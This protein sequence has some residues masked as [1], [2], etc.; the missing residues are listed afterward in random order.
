[1]S[2]ALAP[3]SRVYQMGGKWWVR[4]FGSKGS[5]PSPFTTKREAIARATA[6]EIMVKERGV[7]DADELAVLKSLAPPERGVPKVKLSSVLRAAGGEPPGG[8]GAADRVHES[9]THVRAR[10]ELKETFSV[11]PRALNESAGAIVPLP[12][13][14]NGIQ[15]YRVRCKMQHCN[16]VNRNRRRYWA[17]KTWG[18]HTR[19]DAP[20]LMRV[21]ARRVFGHLEHPDSGRSNTKLAAIVITNVEKP[22]ETGEVFGTFETMS[23]PDGIIVARFIEDGVGFGLSSRGEGSVVTAPDG[24]DDVTEDFDPRS[25][26]VVADES[27]PGAEVGAELMALRE[28]ARRSRTLLVES[29]GGRSELAAELARCES[30]RVCAVDLGETAELPP[31]GHNQFL[32]GTPDQA[33][34]YRAYQ[35]GLAQWSVWFQA[36]NLPPFEVARAMPTLKDAKAAAEAHLRWHAGTGAEPGD[37]GGS[38]PPVPLATPQ[39]P[40][41]YAA[42]GGSTIQAPA[43]RPVEIKVSVGE[44]TTMKKATRVESYEVVD[45]DAYSGVM[46]EL[47]YFEDEKELEKAADV[48]ADAGFMVYTDGETVCIYT[49]IEDPEQAVAHVKRALDAKDITLD[50]ATPEAAASSEE[51]DAMAEESTGVR[52]YRKGQVVFES[53]ASARKHAGD[54]GLAA[55]LSASFRAGIVGVA[56]KNE[57]LGGEFEFDDLDFEPAAEF[58]VTSDE[59]IPGVLGFYPLDPDADVDSGESEDPAAAGAN[60]AEDPMGGELP[61]AEMGFSSGMGP[62]YEMGFV[63]STDELPPNEPNEQG[64]PSGGAVYEIG[65]PAGNLPDEEG[66]NMSYEALARRVQQMEQKLGIA[67]GSGYGAATPMDD[68]EDLDLNL[69]REMAPNMEKADSTPVTNNVDSQ[70]KT[71]MESARKYHREALRLQ[72]E[73]RKLHARRA[74]ASGG[75]YF[76]KINRMHE[77]KKVGEVRLIFNAQDRLVEMR[78]INGAGKL[79]QRVGFLPPVA[80]GKKGKKNEADKKDDEKDKKDERKKRHEAAEQVTRKV[81]EALAKKGADPKAIFESTMLTFPIVSS[82]P[83]GAPRKNEA[84]KDDDKDKKDKKEAENPEPEKD[85]KKRKNEADKDDDKKKDKK[86]EADKKKDD[87]KDKKEAKDDDEKD[88]KKDETIRFLQGQVAQLES[89]KVRL[90][91]LLSEVARQ[92]AKG[93]LVS[94]RAALFQAHPELAMP[95]VKARLMKHESVEELR[96]DAKALLAIHEAVAPKPT[97]TTPTNGTSLPA[98]GRDKVSATSVTS[99]HT[100]NAPK[101][102]LGE[103]ASELLSG[104]SNLGESSSVGDTASRTA[105][106]RRRRQQGE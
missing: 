81:A 76:T 87:E 106:Y 82:G 17:D 12:I 14:R 8:W 40:P 71:Y 25:V 36:H 84:E 72:A 105:Q 19:D 43:G 28:S 34:H 27:T 80:E 99:T 50:A 89:A 59:E 62:A 57:S 65:V 90:E 11:D 75:A 100:G 7:T 30:A 83:V 33:G 95:D 67:E 24:V 96:T 61:Y 63:D 41:T 77:G 64:N 54:A 35:D 98:A 20:F 31:Q 56:P 37:A 22:L 85:E 13:G 39:T 44:S 23:T 29:A 1:M 74:P 93:Q 45:V 6:N 86:D 97:A 26:D 46:V 69:D 79:T 42:S 60:M 48:L 78:E 88:K 51:A 2:A 15:R 68:P 21:R 38:V 104:L 58:S 52:L 66:C 10:I 73:A 32:L 5:F 102:P 92:Q 49:T 18:R 53:G 16:I 55:V 4:E 91:S 70:V 94:E 9:A 47:D 101:G 3:E 103:D